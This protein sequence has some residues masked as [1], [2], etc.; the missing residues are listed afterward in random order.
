MQWWHDAV[1]DIFKGVAV[2]HPV[3]TAL[4]SVLEQHRLTRY[5]LQKI[6]SSREEVSGQG[7][8]PPTLGALL[9]QCDASHGQLLQLELEAA[10]DRSEASTL[11]SRHLGRALG[12]VEALRETPRL[13]AKGRTW[14]PADITKQLDVSLSS[15]AR[16]EAHPQLAEACQ[17]LAQ[18][19]QVRG[20]GG[21]ELLVLKRVTCKCLRL[22]L[23]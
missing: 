21:H 7:S 8:Q 6:V 17:Q 13:A 20:G 23:V 12:L 9:S 3:L 14:L 5:R 19:A 2:D 22:R 11:A 1:N 10:G 18:E 15:L 16:G 4:Q